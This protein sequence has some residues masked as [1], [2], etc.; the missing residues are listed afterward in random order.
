MNRT[1]NGLIRDAPVY[2]L[3]LLATVHLTGMV[4]NI[5]L[6]IA[7]FADPL[8][9]IKSN[10]AVFIFS[11]TIADLLLSLNILIL[12]VCLEPFIDDQDK[13]IFVEG[14]VMERMNIF[15]VVLFTSYLGLAIERFCSVALPMWHRVNITIRICRYLVAGIWAVCVALEIGFLILKRLMGNINVKFHLA[16]IIFL[17]VM[18]LLTQFVYI[19]S[20]VSIR[21]QSRELQM[22]SDV[23]ETA[24]RTIKLR[25]KNE[26]TFLLTI[27]L[28]CFILAATI[29]PFLTLALILIYNWT[30][31]SVNVGEDG[32]GS[33]I[34]SQHV[35][36]VA[37]IGVN[38][39]LNIFIYAWRLPKYRK[40]FKKLYCD[41]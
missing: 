28:V 18:F 32:G 19:A 33:P 20:C 10:S 35:W 34:P 13:L 24:V 5:L 1:E 39:V 21:K 17:W 3:A 26:N 27:A 41:C 31:N 36:G 25:L 6:I 7:H 30:K 37:A 22:R 16:A 12:I 40:T 8:K 2:V 29:L 9:L 14:I 11:V 4:G 15:F 38:S 23:N